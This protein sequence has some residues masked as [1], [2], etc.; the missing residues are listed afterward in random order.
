[1]PDIPYPAEPLPATNTNPS[2]LVHYGQH[3]VGKTESALALPDSITLI[4]RPHSADHLVGKKMDIHVMCEQGAFG[5]WPAGKDQLEQDRFVCKAYL[6]VLKDLA[7]RRGAGQPVAK[8]VT[9]DDAGVMENM[10]FDLAL[11]DFRST[12]IGSSDKFKDLKRITDLPGQGNQGSPGWAWVWEWFDRLLWLIRKASE[13][14][15]ILA[16]MREKVVN[17]ETG[18]VSDTDIDLTGRMRKILLREASA[19]GFMFRD[20][21]GN[22]IVSFKSATNTNVGAWCRHLVGRDVILGRLDA[23]RVTQYDWTTIY[24][25]QK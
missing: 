24:P 23:N 3:K 21:D 17:K 25:T 4:L 13:N 15:I 8:Y 9:H 6:S 10:V 22:L 7:E 1:M 12:L 11:Q 14:A 20:K 16:H 19:T 18:E 2:L 5:K